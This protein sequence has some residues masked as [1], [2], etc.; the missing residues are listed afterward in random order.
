[1]KEKFKVSELN[2]KIIQD[3]INDSREPIKNISKKTIQS[4][5]YCLEKL[6]HYASDKNIINLTEKELKQF[7]IENK[8]FSGYNLLGTK[9]II[10]YRWVE[11]LNK[12]EVPKRMAWFIYEKHKPLDSKQIKNEFIT[13]EE[14]NKILNATGKDRFGMW[15]ACW[16]TFY[17]SGA[18]LE[19]IASMKIKHV[20]FNNNKVIIYVPISK[21]QTREIALVKYPYLLERWMHN[22]PY[23]DNPDTPLWISNA[24]NNFGEHLK[25]GSIGMMFW[26][27]KK[28]TDIK[29]NLSVHNFRK[30]RMTLM[31]NQRSKDG[32]L[33][34]SDKQ[35][36]MFFGWSLREVPNRRQEYDLTGFEE[37]KETIFKQ[38][39]TP[40]E[41]YDTIKKENQQMTENF[42][43]KI[44]E[45]ERKLEISED[46]KKFMQRDMKKMSESFKKEMFEIKR[47]LNFI[48]I[49]KAINKEALNVSDK[50]IL[51][52][53]EEG[54]QKLKDKI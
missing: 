44:G 23:K 2:K 39:K 19:E 35:L 15:Q 53:L 16:E 50:R 42:T 54:I 41:S 13:E 9:F 45:L 40:I 32:G 28:K 33:I 31:C 11:K 46:D 22:H 52:I 51:D 3:F 20:D 30:T 24:T 8:D 5:R 29:Q 18:R 37:L 1:M 14:Y 49:A 38:Y 26:K 12:R 7:F 48:L 36:A 6:S 21:T 17:L 25:K 4:D 27:I 47:T 34:Y 43:K 10:F